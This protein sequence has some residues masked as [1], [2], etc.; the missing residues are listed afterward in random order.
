MNRRSIIKSIA[1]LP[2]IGFLKTSEGGSPKIIFKTV[3]SRPSIDGDERYSFYNDPDAPT[4]KKYGF[5]KL[6]CLKKDFLSIENDPIGKLNSMKR[7]GVEEVV[8]YVD[9][10]GYMAMCGF[11]KG[12]SVM[13]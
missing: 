5:K 10:N 8:V 11:K 4:H 3:E 6:I 9:Q 13:T 2:F 7:I 12:L 1:V